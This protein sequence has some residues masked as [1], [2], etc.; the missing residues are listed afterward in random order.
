MANFMN[1]PLSEVLQQL[2][3]DFSRAAQQAQQNGHQYVRTSYNN[4]PKDSNVKMRLPVDTIETA[5]A[6]W[7]FA[8]LPGMEKKDVQV[9]LDCCY[10]CHIHHSN[11]NSS[12]CLI[13]ACCFRCLT[14][15]V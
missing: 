5:D 13:S 7:Y 6:I 9:Y 11:V 1:K 3:K 2:E 14:C 8:D 4:T 10:I 12:A 15:E